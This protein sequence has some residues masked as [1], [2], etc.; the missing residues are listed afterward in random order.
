VVVT[1]V[2][3]LAGEQLGVGAKKEFLR[4]VGHRG[5]PL[6]SRSA[7]V[8]TLRGL[9]SRYRREYRPSSTTVSDLAKP[10]GRGKV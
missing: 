7:F 1:G 4:R 2:A 10:T 9:L 8:G 6:R 3:L 5:P